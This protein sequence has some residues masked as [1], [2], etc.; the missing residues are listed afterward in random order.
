MQYFFVIFLKFFDLLPKRRKEVIKRV[1]LRFDEGSTS[2]GYCALTTET[3]D[4]NRVAVA[5]TVGA[6]ELPDS[7]EGER[8]GLALGERNR[9]GVAAELSALGL[10]DVRLNLIGVQSVRLLPE[11]DGQILKGIIM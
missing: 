7:G 1:L 11:A 10:V 3:G 8:D 2:K 4:I 6:A 9:I 5:V